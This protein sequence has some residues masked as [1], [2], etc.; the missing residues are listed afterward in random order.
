MELNRLPNGTLEQFCD[1]LREHLSARDAVLNSTDSLSLDYAGELAAN[2][3]R[4][5]KLLLDI[6]EEE[7]LRTGER[8]QLHSLEQLI[9]LCAA[10]EGKA[11]ERRN[12]LATP[13]SR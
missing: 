1:A 6:Y 7:W 5:R 13:Q 8:E 2:C 12:D 10:L 9:E 11:K 3:E 4:V